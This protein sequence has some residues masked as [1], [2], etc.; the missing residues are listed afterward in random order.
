MADYKATWDF[1]EDELGPT[2][3]VK[4]GNGHEIA[5]NF[6]SNGHPPQITLYD[7]S[8]GFARLLEDDDADVFRAGLAGAAAKPL[9]KAG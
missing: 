4:L 9:V 5:V 6:F 2:L 7:P 3:W 1:G 8:C